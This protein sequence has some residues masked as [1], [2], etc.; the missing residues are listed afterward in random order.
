MVVRGERVDHRH[1]RRAR[2]APTT[3]RADAGADHD[4]V[5]VAGE[6]P[7]R[8]GDRLAA[9]R[10]AARRRAGPA[11]SPPSSATPTSNETRVRVEGCSKTS[12]TL[13]AGERTRPAPPLARPPSA[14]AARSSSALELGA[15]QLLA[16]EEV[17]LGSG[18]PFK[19][20]PPILWSRWRS[21]ALTWNL[22][23]GR[24]Y[25]PDRALDTWRSRLLRRD[26]ARTHPRP[27]QPRPARRVRRRA[28]RG[29]VGRRPAPGVPAA[30][31]EPAGAA[32]AAPSRT[33]R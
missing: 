3:A 23:H 24:D 17:R 21:R 9:R 28:R 13:R 4:R 16:G 18:R 20:R 26:R 1:R 8:V 22:F 33:A 30:L 10:A 25:P 32:P 11:A 7:G 5:D 12:A 14:R 6:D 15:R 31:G 2:P 29:A 27:G 19:P